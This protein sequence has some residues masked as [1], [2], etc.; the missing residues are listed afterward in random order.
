MRRSV[1]VL[2]V[3][4]LALAVPAAATAA[5]RYVEKSGSDALNDC[6]NQQAPCAHVQYAVGQAAPGDTI[7]VGPGTFTE[8]VTAN[9]PLTFVGAGGGSLLAN[10]GGTTIQPPGAGLNA[11]GANGMTLPAGGTVRS[12]R[13]QGADGGPS[14]GPSGGA[15][16]AGIEYESSGADPTALSLDGVVVIAG[17]GGQGTQPPD[18]GGLGT[19]GRGI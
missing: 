15:G 12:M 9:V 13:V 6:T 18:L 3:A 11:D 4:V 16:G 17:D 10:P 2:V 19:A 14:G 8:S 7:Q 5:T 1:A